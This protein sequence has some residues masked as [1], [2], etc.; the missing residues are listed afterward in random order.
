M[1]LK[2]LEETLKKMPDDE[3]VRFQGQHENNAQYRILAE[4]EFQRRERAE[5]H[6]LDLNLIADQVRWMKFSAILSAAA[7]IVAAIVGAIGGAILTFW[8]QS[9][10]LQRQ[11]ELQPRSSQQESAPSTSV[12]RKEK[13]ESVPSKTP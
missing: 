1:A 9:K 6:E 8:L 5:Q 13:A 4:K 12:D 10:L 11:L 7:A 3:L 2:E